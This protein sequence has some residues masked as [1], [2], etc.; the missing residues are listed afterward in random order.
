MKRFLGLL[1][2]LICSAFFGACVLLIIKRL[3]EIIKFFPRGRK[4]CFLGT[5][6]GRKGGNYII[7]SAVKSLC[8]EMFNFLSPHFPMSLHPLLLILL[9]L[10]FPLD[11][12]IVQDDTPTLAQ[13]QPSLIPYSSDPNSV[14]SPTSSDLPSKSAPSLTSTDPTPVPSS[15]LPF[16]LDLV[17]V[18]FP[19]PLTQ[20]P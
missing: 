17:P 10:I 3:K 4:F 8:R 12:S 18:S 11:L 15:F 16:P 19:L 5:L 1:L 14:L 7:W 2:N 13:T 9:L 6:Q 20:L